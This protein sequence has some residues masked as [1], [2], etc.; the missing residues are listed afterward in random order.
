MK[1]S[2]V[3][4]F[5]SFSK[6]RQNW[7]GLGIISWQGQ[8]PVHWEI[9]PGRI[10]FRERKE[11][12][13]GLQVQKVL[14]LSYGR[15]I[16]KP[17]EKLTGLVPES[18]ETYQIVY[19]GDI[20]IRPTDLQNDKTSLRIG[21][22][23]DHGII[24]SAYIDLVVSKTLNSRF[25][26]YYLHYLDISKVIYHLGSGLR[27]N[28][29]YDDFKTFPLPKP[30]FGEQC[31]IVTYLDF[32]CTQIDYF[33]EKKQKLI[34]LLK[35]KKQAIINNTVTKGLHPGV[36]MKPSKVE[37]LGDVP[38]DWEIWKMTRLTYRIGDGLH[39][40]PIYDDTTDIPFINGNNL[41]N[42]EI[43][44]DNKTRSV[45]LSEY[46]K[47]KLDLKEGTVLMSIN[48]TIGNLAIYRPMKLILGKSAAYLECR[49]QILNRFLFYVLHSTEL[50]NH[51][52]S[53]TESTT[54][55]NVSLESLRN[56]RVAIPS[57][58]EQQEIIDYL[59][60]ITTNT[61]EAVK[62][63]AEEIILIREYKDALVAEVVTGKIDVS[64]W[65]SNNIAEVE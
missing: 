39:G 34:D 7:P 18:F 52:L 11:K 30:P 2:E 12:N 33:I 14:S 16:V 5:E 21:Q 8:L 44:V 50:I 20:I 26:Y 51:Y 29:N 37:W 42:G 28:L 1:S 27:Q 57:V 31:D 36:T 47:H 35:E 62:S 43:V 64:K 55:K 38:A 41:R 54:I 46:R 15:I 3:K 23:S 10:I 32:K 40:T 65:S 22:S 58:N 56:T 17:P 6:P 9:V 24:T 49:P 48:G 19:P 61:S 45:S 53:I 60:G 13:E 63:I 4:R 25:Y 59:D